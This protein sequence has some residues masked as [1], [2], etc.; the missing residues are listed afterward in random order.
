M[1]CNGFWVSSEMTK[2]AKKS[3]LYLVKR[4]LGTQ[5]LCKIRDGIALDLHGCGVPGETGSRRW[6][7]PGCVIHKVG[8]KGRIQDLGIL[9]IPGQLVDNGT[10][11]LQVAQFLSTCRGVNL[12]P[13]NFLESDKVLEGFVLFG[14]SCTKACNFLPFEL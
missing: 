9:Q 14:E 11:H 7:D 6:I 8:R 12:Y 10:D 1:R 5:I 3:M 2:S 13:R 4:S